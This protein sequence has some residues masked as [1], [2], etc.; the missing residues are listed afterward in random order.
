MK[1]PRS[2]SAIGLLGAAILLAFLNSA[3]AQAS[4]PPRELWLYCPTNLLVDANVEKLEGIWKR[5]AKAGYTNVL[6]ED[7]KFNRLGQMPRGYFD[8]VDRV[9]KLAAGLGL[10]IV[11]A[12]FS[13]GYSND[14]LGQDP[15]LAEGLPVRETPFVVNGGEARVGPD[16]A[17]P[18][19]KPQFKDDTVTLGGNIATMRGDDV[20]ARLCYH[21]TLPQFRC[22][23][24]SVQIKTDG[25]TAQAAIEA[26]AGDRGLNYQ[27]LAIKPTQDWTAYNIVFDTLD[28]SDVN[29][30]FGVWD[31]FKGTIQWKD[32]KIEEIGLVNVLRREGTP[33]VVKGEGDIVYVEGRDYARIED[34]HLGNVPYGG[35]Y[36]SWHE[37]P[38]IKVLDQSRLP[39]GTKLRVS[40]YYPPIIYDG[41][42]AA[43]ISDP[44]LIELLA[45]QARRM[46]Q[47]WGSAAAG[48][49]MSH[50]EFRCS[51][52]DKSSAESGKT[53][54]EL[55][56]ENLRNCTNLLR[57]SAVYV[58]S[59]M[60]DPNHNAVPGPYYLV[61][62][63]WTGSWEGLDK[64][65]V[66][67]N[68]NFG[69]RDASLK[70]FADRGNRQLIAGYYD[71]NQHT[72]DWLE[73]AS[74]VRGVI[75][76][77]YTTWR[78]DYSNIEKFAGELRGK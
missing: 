71:N 14:L 39:D 75:G 63:P 42:V 35:E 57:P 26:L 78:N 27:N 77:M 44:H 13:I 33:C 53:P 62:G 76:I 60:F 22:Y 54:G 36:Q 66:V 74:K 16:S 11:P 67:V 30:Y 41:Q 29:L 68:W 6:L 20:H 40:W 31:H 24:V 48:Y 56:A 37:P 4:D 47:A 43:C 12:V 25:F 28:H 5:A 32:W 18:L 15:N 64:D 69:K 55:L 9:K 1:T 58:W 38:A 70:F 17:I 23:H 52:W 2:F 73:S 3:T 34:P 51:G 59:D 8:N 50:D 65:V 45:D 19:G 7:S 49:M 21:L 46:K 72:A 61:N 10:K